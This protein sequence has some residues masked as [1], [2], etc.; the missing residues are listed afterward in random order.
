M[1]PRKPN[2]SPTTLKM[3]SVCCSGRKSKRFCVPRVKPF[4][5]MP[6]LPM[7]TLDW[8]SWYPAPRGSTSGSRKTR[9]RFCWYVAREFHRGRD[10][11]PAATL[12]NTTMTDSKRKSRYR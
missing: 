6:P 11:V 12:A 9:I 3:K 5:T 1:V 8:I 2:S 10:M 7:A 4:P